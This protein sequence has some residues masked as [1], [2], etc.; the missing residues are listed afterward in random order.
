[1]V[2]V[3][4]RAAISYNRLVR[5]NNEKRFKNGYAGVYSR[6]VIAM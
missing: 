2:G 6:S 4:F 3:L 5:E 1:M